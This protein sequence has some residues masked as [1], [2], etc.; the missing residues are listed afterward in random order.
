M[1]LVNW[2]QNINKDNKI[3]IMELRGK[4]IADLPLEEGIS[5]AGK[6]W[7][8]KGW[9]LETFDQFPRQVKFDVFGD[10]TATL[11]FEVQKSYIIQVD[12][13]S[14]EFNGRWYTDITAYNSQPFD[15]Q[16]GTMQSGPQFH[17]GQPMQPE[18]PHTNGPV[19]NQP[20]AFASPQIPE[21][22]PSEDL[23]F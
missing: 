7:K 23:P 19:F 6:P 17:G 12:A 9:V 8:K 16:Q 3:K 13:Q 1:A 15:M 4:I 18:A 11:T 20:A 5:K 10:R 22:D 21:Q 14:R 2:R